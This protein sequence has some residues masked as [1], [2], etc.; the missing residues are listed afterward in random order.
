[1]PAVS[2]LIRRHKLANG[3]WEDVGGYEFKI[4]PPKARISTMIHMRL[5]SLTPPKS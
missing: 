4:V 3:R 1:M 5:G 2:E